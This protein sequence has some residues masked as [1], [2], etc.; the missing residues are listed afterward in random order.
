MRLALITLMLT[1]CLEGIEPDVGPPLRQLCTNE[2][3]DPDR[4]VSYD[5]IARGIFANPAYGCVD[6]HTPTGAT[7][8]GLQVSGLDLSSLATL[9]SGGT[10]SGGE[11]VIAGRPCDSVLVQKIGQSPP[12]GAR[13]PLDGPPFLNELDRQLIAD[14]IAEGALE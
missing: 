12:F 9:R 6:C 14:W 4:R 5:D 1:G 11:I 8:I 10:R 3:S 13:M 7:P 2:D